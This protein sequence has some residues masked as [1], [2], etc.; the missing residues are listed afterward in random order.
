[1]GRIYLTAEVSEKTG[2]IQFVGEKPVSREYFLRFITENPELRTELTAE[3]T[4]VVTAPAYS[5]S[6]NQNIKLSS[7]LER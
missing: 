6:G 3:G 7:Q 4:I 2:P 5:H 1:M